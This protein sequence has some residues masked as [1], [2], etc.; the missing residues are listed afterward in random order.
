MII[1]N[2][3]DTRDEAWT[4]L[5]RTGFEMLVEN[6]QGLVFTN[7]ATFEYRLLRRWKNQWEIQQPESGDE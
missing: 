4:E 3:F 6:S 2:T 7:H 5:S 1:I